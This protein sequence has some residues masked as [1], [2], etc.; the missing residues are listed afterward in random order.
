MNTFLARLIEEVEQRAQSLQRKLKKASRVVGWGLLVVAT[1]FNILAIMPVFLRPNPAQRIA[2]IFSKGDI[3]TTFLLLLNVATGIGLSYA[4]TH[5]EIVGK[6][7]LTQSSL[8]K[9]ELIGAYFFGIAFNFLGM[10]NVAPLPSDLGERIPLLF[11]ILA[12]AVLLDIVPEFMIEDAEANNGVYQTSPVAVE[13]TLPALGSSKC[14]TPSCPRDALPG[15]A[16]C[17]R[18]FQQGEG[19]GSFAM[20]PA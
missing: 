18:H 13:E 16:Q 5:F 4:I 9:I 11:V 19:A 7:R 1:F 12:C 2:E 17:M 8:A 10:V 3:W 14:D 6:A 15:F 20:S